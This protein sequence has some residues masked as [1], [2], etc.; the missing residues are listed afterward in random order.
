MQTA[1]GVNTT[2]TVPAGYRAIVRDLDAINISGGSGSLTMT[3]AGL[4]YLF[5]AQS[6]TYLDYHAWR[7]RQVVNPGETL[8]VSQSGINWGYAVSGYLLTLP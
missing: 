1:V 5:V 8:Q 7:G 2:Y 3:I 6:S 4:A